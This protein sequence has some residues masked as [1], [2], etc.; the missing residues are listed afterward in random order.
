MT[1]IRSVAIA[2]MVAAIWGYF[3]D[4]ST[5]QVGWFIGRLVFCATVAVAG[6]YL[7]AR[8]PTSGSKVTAGKVG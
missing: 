3:V 2:L 6:C 1:M 4:L 5:G 8:H 7:F